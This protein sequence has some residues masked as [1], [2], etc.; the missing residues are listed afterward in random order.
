VHEPFPAY[1]LLLVLAPLAV[2]SAAL[3]WAFLLNLRADVITSCCGSLFGAG[4]EGVSSLLPIN[5]GPVLG[6]SLLLVPP[7]YMLWGLWYFHTGRGGLMFSALSIA[8][9]AV[10]VAGLIAYVSPFIYELPTHC[11]P[12]C[13]LQADYG[14]IGYPLYAGVFLSAALGAG[15]GLMGPFRGKKSLESVLPGLRRGF[16]GAALV[17]YMVFAGLSLWA[18]LSSNLSLGSI[19]N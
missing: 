16:V 11:C 19:F 4:G 6:A 9:L 13:L 3:L 15:A 12:F 17:C 14:F 1:S 18:V 7:A 10:S 8:A 5:R 2:A